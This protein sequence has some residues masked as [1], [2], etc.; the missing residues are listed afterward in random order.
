[1]VRNTLG[2]ILH[3]GLTSPWQVRRGT[4]MQKSETRR[5]DL[6]GLGKGEELVVS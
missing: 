4:V 3:R 2:L 5:T 6:M 1:M